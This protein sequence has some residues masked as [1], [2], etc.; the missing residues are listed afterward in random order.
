[1]I[2][3]PCE[4]FSPVCIRLIF[5]FPFHVLQGKVRHQGDYSSL[6]GNQSILRDLDQ[7]V[8][9]V[10]HKG[11]DNVVNY[12]EVRY[13]EFKISLDPAIKSRITYTSLSAYI[14]TFDLITGY[15]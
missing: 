4:L 13:R 3:R 12:S 10:F 6:E 8:Q 5:H 11:E 14:L 1:M 7:D 15:H 9:S 2:G